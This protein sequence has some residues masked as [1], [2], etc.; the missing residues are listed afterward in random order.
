MKNKKKWISGNYTVEAAF[1]VPMILGIVFAMIYMLF[2]LHDKVILHE[3]LRTCVINLVE[4][5]YEDDSEKTAKMVITKKQISHN[6][7][8]Y[9]I[10]KI[11]YNVG[12]IY[13]SAE[14][15]AVCKFNIPVI[16]YFI[17]S[18]K[19]VNFKTRYLKINPESMVR[20]KGDRQSVN[21]NNG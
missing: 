7:I 15:D 21:G 10:K 13:I 12:K 20:K 11:K 3:N 1:I 8:V 6:L 5:D 2:F 9:K 18:K 19:S 17:N 16:T 14:V 4:K